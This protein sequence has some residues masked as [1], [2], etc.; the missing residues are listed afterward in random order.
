[1]A[2]LRLTPALKR[3]AWG[4]ARALPEILGLPADGSPLAEAWYGAHPQGP[5]TAEGEPLDARIA[6]APEALL[7]TEVAARF[8]GLPYLLKLLAAAR[9]LSIQ[10]HPDPAQAAEG[11]A[12]EDAAG[13]PRDAAHRCYRDPHAKPE[14]IVALTPFD[15]L[16]GFRPLAEV[17]A[18]LDGALRELGAL[19]PRAPLRAL[20][21]AYFGLAEEA[22]EEA[23]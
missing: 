17:H 2:L 18:S 14:L 19:L 12:R 23:L 15:A 20:V 22:R 21:T 13:V 1:M 8:G 3:Y 5:A 6:A 9:P 4:D 10:V 11:F 7:G 16:V